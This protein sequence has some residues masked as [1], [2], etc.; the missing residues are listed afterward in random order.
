MSVLLYESFLFIPIERDVYFIPSKQTDISFK[1]SL[2]LGAVMN[3]VL[4][5][6]PIFSVF[7]TLIHL[8]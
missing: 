7:K 1:Q 5:S 2:F 4:C 6:F 8:L 3:C